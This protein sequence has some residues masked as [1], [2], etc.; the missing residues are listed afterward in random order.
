MSDFHNFY[1]PISMIFFGGSATANLRKIKFC[2][3]LHK[4]LIIRLP[5][6]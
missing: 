4:H 5:L 2:C 3:M 6:R 1:M